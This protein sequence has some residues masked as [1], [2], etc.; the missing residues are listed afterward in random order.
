MQEM[1]WLEVS[2]YLC[3]RGTRNVEKSIIMQV[4]VSHSGFFFFLRSLF[5]KNKT[6]KTFMQ[7]ALQDFLLTSAK[8]HDSL[9]Y[10]IYIL[11]HACLFKGLL[12]KLLCAF[13]V[14]LSATYGCI[15]FFCL[16]LPIVAQASFPSTLRHFPVKPTFQ[17]ETLSDRRK[18]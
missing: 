11:H 2:L 9:I 14:Q 15:N 4:Q 17:T 6:K 1:S 3:C 8:K 10:Y 13:S 12:V 16:S 18:W 7:S 5:E